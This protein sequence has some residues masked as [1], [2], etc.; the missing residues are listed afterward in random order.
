MIRPVDRGINGTAELDGR[1]RQTKIMSSSK[2]KQ[3]SDC[4]YVNILSLIEPIC[5]LRC[6]SKEL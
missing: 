3:P 5:C 2:L 1:A 6:N 4:F